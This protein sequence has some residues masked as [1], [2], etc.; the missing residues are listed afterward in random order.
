[1]ATVFKDSSLQKQFEQKGYI[2]LSSLLNANEIETL[3][4]VFKK[5]QAEFSG[6]FHTSHFS[7]DVI[8]KQQVNDA[9]AAVV[10]PKAALYLNNYLPVFGNFMIKN[11]NPERFMPLHAD[12]TY[13]DESLYCSAAIWVPLVDVDAQNG[14]LGVIDGSHKITN[15]IRGPLI[16]QSSYKHDRDWVTRFGKLIPMK[17]GDAI[18]YNHSLLHYSPPNKS[19]AS[20]PALNLSMAPQNVPLIHYCR[21]EGATEI[22]VYEVNDSSFYI[23]YNNFQRPETGKLVKTL[24]TGI[25]ELIDG[26]MEKLGKPKGLLDRAKGWFA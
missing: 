7:T 12:W 14:C 8:Y 20:R 5:F 22:E 25:I 11:A 15:S 18:I 3:N 19:N 16:Q 17:A 10:F 9:I 4:T 2:L 13:V 26:R 23:H 1:M 24:P 21:P 6:A